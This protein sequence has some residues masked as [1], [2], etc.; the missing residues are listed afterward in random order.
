MHSFLTNKDGF[1]FHP[2]NHLYVRNTILQELVGTDLEAQQAVER[3]GIHLSLDIDKAG[4]VL[5]ARHFNSLAHDFQSAALTAEE[6]RGNHTAYLNGAAF[7]I[8]HKHPGAG[9]Q[10]IAL[11]IQDVSRNQVDVVHVLVQAGLFQD[12][13]LLAQL[14]QLVNLQRCKLIKRANSGNHVLCMLLSGCKSR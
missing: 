7:G 4:V 2:D 13:H 1:L 14:Q 11:V 3:N 8:A 10:F 12:K 9:C 6:G 5:L